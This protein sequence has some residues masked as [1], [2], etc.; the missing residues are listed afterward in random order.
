MEPVYASRY[1]KESEAGPPVHV[2]NIPIAKPMYRDKIVYVAH[3]NYGKPTWYDD[4][5]E[6][7]GRD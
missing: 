7:K 5:E 1:S 6:G 4:G 2:I 3:D